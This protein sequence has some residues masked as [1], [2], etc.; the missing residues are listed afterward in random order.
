MMQNR[1]R[2]I[3]FRLSEEEY[4]EVRAACDAQGSRSVSA[5]VRW[6]VIWMV[7][8]WERRVRDLLLIS[9]AAN[10]QVPGP[11]SSGAAAQTREGA[12]EGAGSGAELATEL[13]EAINE[14]RSEVESLTRIVQD[15][16]SRRHRDTHE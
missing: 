10:H 6:S 5:F 15:L 9:A 14:L 4:E 7:S 11:I 1:S 2:L 16:I 3:T 12:P 13:R 8:N